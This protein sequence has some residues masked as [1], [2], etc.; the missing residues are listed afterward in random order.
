MVACKTPKKK[1][2]ESDGKTGQTRELIL[3]AAEKK[4]RLYLSTKAKTLRWVAWQDISILIASNFKIRVYIMEPENKGFH[5]P[6]RISSHL[7]DAFAFDR[8]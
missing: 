4:V 1:A 5:F 6:R 3:E 8:D 7:Q 2:R